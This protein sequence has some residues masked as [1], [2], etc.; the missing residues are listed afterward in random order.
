MVLLAGG[1]G[2]EERRDRVSILPA[3]DAEATAARPVGPLEVSTDGRAVLLG[4][5]TLFTVER[6][7]GDGPEGVVD[8]VRF[9]RLAF[10]PDSTLV[11]FTTA[12]TDPAAG[13][14]SR[15]S[16][17]G[18]FVDVFRGGHADS[19][20]W[21]PDGRWLAWEGR[22]SEGID[23]VA[24][25]DRA[26]RR[27]RH[28]VVEW[29]LRSGRSTRLVEW[30]D[31]GR[32]HVM[33]ADGRDREGRAYLWD[34]RGSHFILEEHLEPLIEQ[35]SGAPPV[36]GG[37]F[38]LDLDG[39]QVPETVALYRSRDG[40]PAAVVLDRRDGGYRARVA[41]PLIKAAELGLE[42]WD[43]GSGR[44]GLYAPVRFVSGTAVLLELPGARPG[45]AAIGV[46]A[47]AAEGGLET[48]PAT[49]PQGDR[50]AIFF[51]GRIGEESYQLGLVDLD[52][53][54]TAEVVSAVGRMAGSA[55]ERAVRWRATVFREQEG[56]LIPAPELGPAA[57]ERIAEATAR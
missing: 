56:R 18:R 26:G 2:E 7:P 29:V 5:D 38:S 8:P 20:A 44:I 1:C 10:S 40:G 14:W 15:T 43:E 23:R 9:D 57:L 25:S 21:A 51:D 6:L 19:L 46:F 32:L 24:V 39:D 50:P 36:P 37:V 33:V 48:F 31:Q 27:L 47:M 28:P 16:Q 53:D 12:G 52:G 11:A 13:I 17:T 45:L 42:S 30:G 49:T 35:A 22:T 41:D 55:G 3:G 54:A 4:S 34:V